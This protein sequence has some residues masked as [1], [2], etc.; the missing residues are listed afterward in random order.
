M[1]KESLQT[2][3]GWFK[4]LLTAKSKGGM[5]LRII[6]LLVIPYAYLMLCGLIFDRLLHLYGMTTFIFISLIVLYAAA[7]VCAILSVVWTCR[8]GKKQK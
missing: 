2:Q 8:G 3:D 4:R 7:F 1:E 6:I 5:I